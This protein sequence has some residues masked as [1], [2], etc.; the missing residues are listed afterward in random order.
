MK[1]DIVVIHFNIGYFRDWNHRG[2]SVIS[3]Y[4]LHSQHFLHLSVNRVDMDATQQRKVHRAAKN[5]QN[6]LLHLFNHAANAVRNHG[7]ELDIK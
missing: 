7:D 4:L 1:S 5:A 6:H 3:A 2:D